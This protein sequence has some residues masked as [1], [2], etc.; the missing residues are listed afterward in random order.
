MRFALND[1]MA[2]LPFIYPLSGINL[3]N[4]GENSA[5]NPFPLP[6]TNLEL[7]TGQYSEDI[8]SKKYPHLHMISCFYEMM[9]CIVE[10]VM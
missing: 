1:I 4:D 3:S 5:L 8:D 10:S 7:K 2:I 6:Q 9:R